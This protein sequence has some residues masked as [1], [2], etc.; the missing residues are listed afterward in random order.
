MN[1]K[2]NYKMWIESDIVDV[3]TKE[4]EDEYRYKKYREMIKAIE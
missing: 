4:E 3:D 1:Y 2:E